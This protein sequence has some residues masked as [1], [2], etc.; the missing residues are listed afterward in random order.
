MLKRR[1]AIVSLGLALGLSALPVLSQSQSAPVITKQAAEARS[2][3]FGWQLMTASERAEFHERMRS[4]N[5]WQERQAFR[6]EHHQRMLERARERGV[7]LPD[8]PPLARG[9]GTGAGKGAGPRDGTGA[10]GGG[11][12]RGRS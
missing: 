6:E 11:R 3:V 8:E 1:F 12:G 2:V 7:S 4:L 5:T 9:P 10:R